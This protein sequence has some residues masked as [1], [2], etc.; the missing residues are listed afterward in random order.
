MTKKVM[1]L[2]GVV[3]LA[4][5]LA[6]CATARKKE[7]PE[8]LEL[9][10]QVSL[11]EAQLQNKDDEISVLKD[12]LSSA[13][14]QRVSATPP[15]DVAPYTKSAVP[16]SK[17]RFTI[18]QVQTALK[19]AGYDPGRIDGRMG[20]QTRDA[21]KSFQ[22]ANGLTVDGYVGKKTWLVLREYLDKKVK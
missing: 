20:K 14:E 18:R 9:K 22:K 4:I 3:I 11:L 15:A 12:Q 21:V 10:N 16:E 6:G 19:N 5:S 7:G 17:T 8:V 1:L 2:F 13:L